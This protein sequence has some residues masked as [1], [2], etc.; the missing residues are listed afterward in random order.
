ML[1]AS[2]FPLTSNRSNQTVSPIL[3]HFSM[4]TPDTYTNSKQQNYVNDEIAT[5][6]LS[7]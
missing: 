6:E 3:S 5:V 2:S 1:D 4:L 7:A